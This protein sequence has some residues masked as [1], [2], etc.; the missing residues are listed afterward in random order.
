MKPTT[1]RRLS[2][3]IDDAN[4]C[5]SSS[6][7]SRST[8]ET[9]LLAAREHAVSITSLAVRLVQAQPGLLRR[10]P[11]ELSPQVPQRLST[12]RVRPP[13]RRPPV[14]PRCH[15][16]CSTLSPV[17]GRHRHDRRECRCARPRQR[18]PE[19][20]AV[21]RRVHPRAPIA[22]RGPCARRSTASM[23]VR[24][25]AHSRCIIRRLRHPGRARDRCAP[26]ARRCRP[27]PPQA[28]CAGSPRR[29]VADAA[30]RPRDR[31]RPTRRC[32]RT[33]R[34]RAAHAA[35]RVR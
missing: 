31:Q 12:H 3:E 23:H 24:Q 6:Q 25:D 15:L 34:P 27:C 18:L 21:P 28:P 17:R 20:P 2:T 16:R 29:L 26:T 9:S 30:R 13:A 7:A 5:S 33:G 11:G 22:V 8:A 19:R 35:Y 1:L 14:R 10:L 4:I 32:P